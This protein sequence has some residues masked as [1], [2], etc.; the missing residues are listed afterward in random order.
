MRRLGDDDKQ[1]IHRLLNT[2][3]TVQEVSKI[4]GF[5]QLTVRAHLK[6]VPEDPEW[7]PSIQYLGGLGLAL[8]FNSETNRVKVIHPEGFSEVP[9]VRRPLRGTD[10]DIVRG[11][12]S[13]SAIERLAT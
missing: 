13:A 2:G 6:R 4:V 5:S 7:F 10:E 3:Y 12:V 8:G 9:Y 1:L 11:A